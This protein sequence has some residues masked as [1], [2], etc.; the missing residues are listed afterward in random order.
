MDPIIYHVA[1]EGEIFGEFS[2]QEFRRQRSR[3]EL[4][5]TDHFWTEGMS[6]WKE[7]SEWQQPMAATVRMLPAPP[8]PTPQR[9][10]I[11]PSQMESEPATKL[12]A[13]QRLKARRGGKR[14][15]RRPE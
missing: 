12:S 3:G 13:W 8:T 5:P 11:G 1:R 2:A 6:G 9:T 10:M 14:R 7:V 4:K 15:P